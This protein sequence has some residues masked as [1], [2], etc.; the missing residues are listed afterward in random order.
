MNS[1]KKYIPVDLTRHTLKKCSD[2]L[3][4][5]YV[6]SAVYRVHIWNVIA[7]DYSILRQ[8]IKDSLLDRL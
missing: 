4:N 6:P 2:V 3:Q 5:N 7:T 8:H 1:E